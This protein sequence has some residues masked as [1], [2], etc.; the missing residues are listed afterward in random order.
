MAGAGYKLYLTGDVL[1]AT[2]VN[3]YLQEQTVMSFATSAARTSAFIISFG[4][5]YDELFAR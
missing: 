1:S 5:R 3:N 4:R 2:D